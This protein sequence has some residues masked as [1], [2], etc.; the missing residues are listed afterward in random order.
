[1]VRNI[2]GLGL[3]GLLLVIGI[4]LFLFPEPV[5]SGLGISLIVAAVVLWAIQ[6]L[7]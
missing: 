4:V 7:L 6:E 3:V 2:G 5:T 1:M